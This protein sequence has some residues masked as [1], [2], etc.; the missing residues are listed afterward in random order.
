[1]I[2]V[3]RVQDDEEHKEI[4]PAPAW[5]T[6]AKKKT[7]EAEDAHDAGDKPEI[8]DTYKTGSVKRALE[9][10][11]RGKCAYCEHKPAV[12]AAWDVE[13][14]RPKSAV[15]EDS[16]HPG[17]YWLA[18]TW[19]NLYFSCALCNQSRKDPKLWGE[20]GGDGAASGKI[21]QFPL[22]DP[23]TRVMAHDA[24]QDL[25][26]EARL[27][28]DPCADEPA[29]H[30][31]FLATGQVEHHDAIGEKS[32]EVFNLNRRRLRRARKRRIAQVVVLEQ[33]RRGA[34]ADDAQKLKD[35]LDEYFYRE[36]APYAGAA[37]AVR[38]DPDAF[39]IT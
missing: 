14:F 15:V 27:L 1:M 30:L 35:F 29:D 21:H 13:H 20:A 33:L 24:A 5:F 2:H 7:K 6:S 37:R 19:T 38:D 9:R 25:D 18:Y 3:D 11:F 12:G 31:K 34:A 23:T 28:I 36:D 26:D 22:S 16:D 8:S 17:Y 32:I 4:K 39:G 10:L